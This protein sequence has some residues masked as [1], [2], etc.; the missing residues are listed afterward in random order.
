[1]ARHKDLHILF[2]LGGLNRKGSYRQQAPFTSPDLMNVRPQGVLEGRDRGGSRP[3]LITSHVD[4]IGSNPRLLHP[5]VLALGDNFTS[6]S[7]TF[8]GTEL[9]AEWTQAGWASDV[10][11]ILPDALAGIDT[12]T[13]EGEVVR[14]AL[15]IDTANAYTVE[16]LITP[17]SAAYHGE[18][19]LYLRLDDA[20]PAIA[21]DGVEI[22]LA[23]TGSDGSYSCTMTSYKG[24][25]GLGLLDTAS[26]TLASGNAEVGWLSATVVGDVVTVYWNGTQIISETVDTTPAGSRV[27]FGLEC[28][29]EGGLSLINVFRVQY[30]STS[31]IDG[32]RTMLIASAEGDLWRS[33]TYGRMTAVVSNLTV[34]SDTPLT[35]AQSGQKLYIAD[36]GDLRATGTDGTVAGSELD[37]AS[38]AD[39]S[40]LGIDKEDDVVVLSSVGGATVAQTYEIDSIAAGALTLTSAPGNGTCSYRIE[41]GPKIYDPSANTIALLRATAGQVPTGCPLICRYLD[42][43]VFA[44]ADIAPHVWYM[45]RSGTETDFDYSQTDSQ[46]AVAGTS[47]EAGMPGTAILAQ[48]PHSDDYLIWGCRNELWRL[49]GDP[50]Y[51]GAL[52]ALSRTIG[53]LGANAWCLGPVGELIFL[54]LDGLYVLPPGGEASPIPLSREILPQEFKNLDPNEMTISLEFDTIDNG[55]DIFLTPHSSNTRTHWWLDWGTKTFWPLS[56]E[57]DYEPVTTCVYYSTATED[58]CVVLGCRDGFLRRFSKLSGTDCGTVYETY[59]MMGPIGLGRDGT[60]GAAISIEGIM[61]EGAAGTASTGDS[62]DVTWSL[63]PANTFEGAVLA[64]SSDDGT[65]GNGLNACEYPACMGQATILKITGSSGRKWAFEQAILSVRE[66]GR[67]RLP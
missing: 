25:G 15:S 3:G 32:S 8:G 55:V 29:V 64:D 28:T 43:I 1:M 5:M 37:A 4:D 61:A 46:R 56:F 49:R 38:V 36:Y 53:I 51:G 6:Y 30:Y 54:S 52:D 44:G 67:R 9:G 12:D 35:S 33:E 18:Y 11:S 14:D 42:R 16:M 10:P 34:R 24:G 41:R 60:F 66:G 13:A 45:A 59:A 27:G 63:H 31:T 65:W 40:A 2:P 21:T 26:G 58:S 50:A 7:D 39:W 62:G 48:I 47:S 20:T 57:S 19:R 17:W 22:I 23:M